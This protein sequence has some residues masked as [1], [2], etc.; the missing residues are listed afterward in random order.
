MSRGLSRVP[1][2]LV[3]IGRLYFSEAWNLWHLGVE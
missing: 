1:A 2:N 3:L